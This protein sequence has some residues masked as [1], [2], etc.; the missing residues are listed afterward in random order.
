MSGERRGPCAIRPLCQARPHRKRVIFVFHHG[1]RLGVV[2]RPAKLPDVLALE[3]RRRL[4]RG[5]RHLDAAVEVEEGEQPVGVDDR[6]AARVAVDVHRGGAAAQ[7][8]GALRPEVGQ[9]V[10][11]ERARV[12]RDEQA[13]GRGGDGDDRIGRPSARPRDRE[14]LDALRRTRRVVDVEGALAPS[15]RRATSAAALVDGGEARHQRAVLPDVNV[16]GRRGAHVVRRHR[17][18]LAPPNRLRVE[19]RADRQHDEVVRAA[20]ADAVHLAGTGG[21][22]RVDGLHHHGVLAGGGDVDE[23]LDVL[24]AALVGLLGPEEDGPVGALGRVYAHATCRRRR[25]TCSP[26][27]CWQSRCTNRRRA[28]GGRAA[29]PRARG[30]PRARHLQRAQVL[31]KRGRAP[32]TPPSPPRSGCRRPR[33]PSPTCSTGSTPRRAGVHQD[34]RVV[35]VAAH[36][37]RPAFS[38]RSRASAGRRPAFGAVGLCGW[39]WIGR[40]KLRQCA[41]PNCAPPNCAAR[42]RRAVD[43]DERGLRRRRVEGGE[44]ER[45]DEG[46]ARV[47]HVDLAVERAEQDVPAVGRPAH[48]GEPRLELLP[49]QPFAVDGADDHHPVLVD[50]AD[51]LAVGRPPHPRTV[52]LFQLLII[53]SNHICLCS[54]H[55]IISPFSS[56]VVSF[57]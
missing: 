12:A 33:G 11:H 53:S 54:I 24:D 57:R 1:E 40:G 25:P 29:L 5:H 21:A 19:R 8:E 28:R 45:R 14:R 47:V 32:P 52:D 15:F 17:D 48:V 7:L 26:G 13:G 44:V 30:D 37:L 20:H 38:S 6:D 43:A 27:G 46:A 36:Q 9:R 35:G 18:A 55:T 22:R 4:R 16:V 39:W 2:A 41:P 51:P 23:A 50:D 56:D 10:P 34:G 31:P 3:A 42:R 49:P